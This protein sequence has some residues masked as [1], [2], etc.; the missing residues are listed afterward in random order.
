MKQKEKN[1]ITF[2]SI[3]QH[4]PVLESEVSTTPLFKSP[5]STWAMIDQQFIYWVYVQVAQMFGMYLMYP[6]WRLKSF[7]IDGESSL[8]NLSYGRWSPRDMRG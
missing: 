8:H 2:S 1:V 4:I 7:L 6:T 5:Y 3:N